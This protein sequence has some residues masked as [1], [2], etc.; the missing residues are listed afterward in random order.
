M[1]TNSKESPQKKSLYVFSD[2]PDNFTLDT[3][4]IENYNYSTIV[5]VMKISDGWLMKYLNYRMI[6]SFGPLLVLSVFFL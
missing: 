5:N 2:Y 4:N 1:T 3:K 6:Y